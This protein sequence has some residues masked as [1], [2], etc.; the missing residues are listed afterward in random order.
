MIYE[1]HTNHLDVKLV[2]ETTRPDH[3][4]LN[5]IRLDMTKDEAVSE[6]YG[7]RSGNE[8]LD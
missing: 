8:L 6:A 2:V 7:Q 5:P 3:N 1:I 4:P